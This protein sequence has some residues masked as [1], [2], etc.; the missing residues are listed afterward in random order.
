MTT[1]LTGDQQKLYEIFGLGTWAPRSFRSYAGAA[2]G[3]HEFRYEAE[4]R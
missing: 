4:M 3:R 1:E 2:R